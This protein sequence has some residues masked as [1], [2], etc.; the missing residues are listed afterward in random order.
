VLHAGTRREGSQVLTAGGRVLVV[1]AT[2]TTLAAARE[3]AYEAAEIVRFRGKHFRRDIAAQALGLP[4]AEKP[5]P[6]SSNV[7]GQED[8]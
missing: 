6:T 8:H 3:A 5:S 2:G 1:T 7:S 4:P